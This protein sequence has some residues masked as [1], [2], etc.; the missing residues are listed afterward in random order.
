M[1]MSGREGKRDGMRGLRDYD[2]WLTWFSQF[3]RYYTRKRRK[4]KTFVKENT[5]ETTHI[6]NFKAKLSTI[7][8]YKL[9]KSNPLSSIQDYQTTACDLIYSLL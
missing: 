2:G 7:G 9:R 4:N 6:L 3:T 5:A 1:E 8:S